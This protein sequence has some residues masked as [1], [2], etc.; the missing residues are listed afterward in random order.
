MNEQKHAKKESLREYDYHY[1][2]EEMNG[3]PQKNKTESESEESNKIRYRE[4]KSREE[5]LKTSKKNIKN[6]F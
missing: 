6:A 1:Y 2:S 4:K 3:L 5:K